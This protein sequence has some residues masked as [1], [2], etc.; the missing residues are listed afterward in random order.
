MS[1][2][3]VAKS[4]ATAVICV[5]VL[6]CSDPASIT[7]P[8]LGE[9]ADSSLSLTA[10]ASTVTLDFGCSFLTV[11]QPLQPD[12]MGRFVLQG[13]TAGLFTQ[14]RALIIGGQLAGA[15]LLLDLT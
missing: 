14:P 4:F 1:R 10:T 6:S 7:L 13:T 12:S 5:L 2:V 8:T 15:H 9:W 3:H 11:N